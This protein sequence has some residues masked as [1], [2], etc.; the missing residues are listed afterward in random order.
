M[1]RYESLVSSSDVQLPVKRYFHSQRRFAGL[2]LHPKKNSGST[3]TENTCGTNPMAVQKW[4]RDSELAHM[5][6]TLE[7][8]FCG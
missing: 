6:F 5:T 3:W 4:C 2:I 1:D 7:Q 8:L